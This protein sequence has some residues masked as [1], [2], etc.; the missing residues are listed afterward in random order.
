MDSATVDVL[1]I[2]FIKCFHCQSLNA[3]LCDYYLGDRLVSIGL[4]DTFK[5]DGLNQKIVFQKNY[6]INS[7]DFNGVSWVAMNFG[8]ELC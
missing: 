6:S 3:N 8:K 2:R 1:F 5:D 7:F 4:L